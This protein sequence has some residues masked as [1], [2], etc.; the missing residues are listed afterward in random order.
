MPSRSL[1]FGSHLR[2]WRIFVLSLL[3]PL[4]PF[5]ADKFY[6]RLSLIPAIS[7]T[8]SKSLLMITS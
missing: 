5:G 3:R 2:S 4:T 6:L 8:I 7:S 1:M